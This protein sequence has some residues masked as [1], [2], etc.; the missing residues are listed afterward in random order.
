MG[1]LSKMCVGLKLP[2]C[3]PTLSLSQVA[4]IMLGCEADLLLRYEEEWRPQDRDPGSTALLATVMDDRL[5]VANV[6]DCRL[7]LVS[8]AWD[9]LGNRTAFVSRATA[10]HNCTR[11][12]HEARRVR[13]AG[14]DI[15]EAGYIGSTLEVSRSMG[16]F[17]TKTEVGHGVIIA[18]PEVYTW[19]LGPQELLAIAVSDV[20][21]ASGSLWHT[22]PHTEWVRS[23]VFIFRARERALVY[24]RHMWRIV[25]IILWPPLSPVHGAG[26][27]G[28]HG[29]P[30]DLQH[31]HHAPQ[32]QEAPQRPSLCSQ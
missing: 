6:G 24:C 28:H 31:G 32:R 13:A 10:D 11:N 8:E 25:L 19:K 9:T 12:P 18:D 23:A 2:A 26:H 17:L 15:D 30:G 16:D 21:D 1:S 3:P 5:L 22:E 20:S 27:L 7:L 4:T 14:G 29:R